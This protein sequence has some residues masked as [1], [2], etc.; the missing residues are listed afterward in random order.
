V[1]FTN[2]LSRKA[3]ELADNPPAALLFYWEALGRQVRIEGPAERAGA[4]ES[5]A[6]ARSRARASQLSALASPQSRVIANREE[7][8]R[9]VS[10]LAVK[11]EGTELLPL[12]ESWGGYRIRPERYEFWQQ[13]DDRLHDRLLYTPAG[14]EWRIERLAP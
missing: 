3:H 13:R 10:E 14:D 2:Y 11:Y 6:Y 7:L 8:E 9:W 4:E 1:F 5:V 12:H